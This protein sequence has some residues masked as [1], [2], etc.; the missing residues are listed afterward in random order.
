MAFEWSL[1]TPNLTPMEKSIIKICEAGMYNI[2]HT[3]ENLQRPEN[4]PECIQGQI[5]IIGYE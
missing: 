3:R 1:P 4:I 5:L 2:I